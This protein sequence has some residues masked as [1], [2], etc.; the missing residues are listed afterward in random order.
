[1]HH[2]RHSIT[3]AHISD[4]PRIRDISHESDTVGPGGDLSL[5]SFC[6]YKTT[7]GVKRTLSWGGLICGFYVY[8]SYYW[9]YA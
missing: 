1:M 8:I 5:L 7:F 3:Y 6:N 2:S 9:A 4:I